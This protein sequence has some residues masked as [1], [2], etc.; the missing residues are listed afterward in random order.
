[1]YTSLSDAAYA[2]SSLQKMQTV[3]NCTE[4]MHRSTRKMFKRNKH[5]FL[6]L[7]L[8]NLNG[9]VFNVTRTFLGYMQGP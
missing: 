3:V 9:Q 2:N 8:K 4:C 7:I 1:M 5:L 6:K